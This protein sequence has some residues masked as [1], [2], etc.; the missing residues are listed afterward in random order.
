VSQ[1]APEVLDDLPLLR[2]ALGVQSGTG[3]T[4]DQGRQQRL[5][6]AV[7]RLLTVS[8]GSDGVLFADRPSHLDASSQLV[9]R[10]LA[11][12]TRLGGP[13]ILIAQRSQDPQPIQAD[14]V[15]ELEPLSTELSTAIAASILE[16]RHQPTSVAAE[17]A[18]RANGLPRTVIAFASNWSP[19][20]TDIPSDV[21]SLIAMQIDNLPGDLRR[22]TRYVSVMGDA[23]PRRLVREVLTD[24]SD[25]RLLDVARAFEDPN[26]LNRLSGLLEVTGGDQIRFVDP[27]VSQ[28]AY[29]GLSFRRRRQLHA[30]TGSLLEL[31]EETHP[32]VLARHFLRGGNPAKAWRWAQRA[33]D[34]A[35]AAGAFNES[36]DAYEIA[37]ES[38]KSAGVDPDEV[39]RT[40]ER[41]A[42]SARMAGR[43]AE[44][45]QAYRLALSGAATGAWPRLL[46]KRAWV[47]GDLGHHQLA[48]G[49][50]SR[51]IKA[52]DGL[53]RQAARRAKAAAY[54]RRA[55]VRIRQGNFAAAEK[56][57]VTS[58]TF[59]S[60]E[61]DEW[62]ARA[63]LLLDAVLVDTGRA[64][65]A[66]TH[67][68]T[69]L[70]MYTAL[71]DWEGVGQVLNNYGIDAYWQGDLD[72]ATDWY[73]QSL[74][75]FDRAGDVVMMAAARNNL[76]EVASDLGD[77]ERAEQEFGAFLVTAARAGN[78][79]F[80][81]HA[82]MNLAV[83]LVRKGRAAEA[84][85][86]LQQAVSRFEGLGSEHFA[87]QARV[88]RIEALI[89]A[90]ELDRAR[91]EFTALNSQREKRATLAPLH[92]TLDE[93]G[94]RLA[95]V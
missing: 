28:I 13:R 34:S 50:A 61:G 76:G 41:W 72:A 24:E 9:L 95:A 19:A 81:A 69:A 25:A 78:E 15:L 39:S 85:T 32:A 51:S 58:L 42:D 30:R 80:E 87:D 7:A 71:G 63:H 36:A 48:L 93:L 57:L 79:Q 67:R 54:V 64:E 45:S 21:E 90:G 55:G 38:A 1:R 43:F 14:W 82:Y 26:F 27:L 12:N 94:S 35:F 75:A 92:S 8:L 56:E 22:L 52:A 31:Q 4:E 16:Q 86:L 84:L 33:G 91:S 44:A 59:A 11:A 77:L 89:E 29:R 62:S 20:Q 17:L 70:A 65:A 23:V 53:P 10:D 37:I 73:E 66:L 83:V 46:S 68:E 2:S 47:E 40:A 3:G 88:H 6:S 5:V 74:A 60:A 18:E 49:L